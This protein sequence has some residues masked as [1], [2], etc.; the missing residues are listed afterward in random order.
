M[1][2]VFIL[3]ETDYD[4]SDALR[5]GEV[6]VIFKQ[7]RPSIFD[8]PRFASEFKTRMRQ[9]QFDNRHDYFLCIGTAVPLL[10]SSSFLIQ[11]YGWFKALFF[12]AAAQH[13]TMRV[14]GHENRESRVFQSHDGDASDVAKSPRRSS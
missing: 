6:T 12:H 2:R 5:Y 13:Y 1:S 14:L 8:H 7:G 11:E 3:S 10:L 4:I 9:L